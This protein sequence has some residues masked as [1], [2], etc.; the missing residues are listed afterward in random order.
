MAAEPTLTFAHLAIPLLALCIP[1][2]AIVAHFL[3][4]AYAERQRHETLREFARAGLPVPPE[5][6]AE[7]QAPSANTPLRLLAPALVNL[8]LGLGIMALFAAVSPGS[9]LWA[10]GFVPLGL[11]A[12]LL[13]LWFASR[14]PA[15]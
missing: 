9:W 15:P 4:K 10:I 1:L 8:G 3:A 11:G 7:V 12:A 13:L 2:V 5:L 6:L 14:K